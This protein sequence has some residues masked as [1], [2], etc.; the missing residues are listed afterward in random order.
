MF[1]IQN[2]EGGTSLFVEMLKEYMLIC[3]NPEGVH[4][5][6]KFGNPCRRRIV[7]FLFCFS[8]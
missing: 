5:K 8:L 2:S 6:K 4:S 7:A 1:I 3:R